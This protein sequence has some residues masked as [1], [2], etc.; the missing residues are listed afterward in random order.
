[1]IL[2]SNVLRAQHYHAVGQ[3]LQ[4]SNRRNLELKYDPT[5][6]TLERQDS[7]KAIIYSIGKSKVL[8]RVELSLNSNAAGWELSCKVPDSTVVVSV[9]FESPDGQKDNNK[10]KGYLL[11]LYRKSKPL[12]FAY[13]QMSNMVSGIPYG[14]ERIKKDQALALT[15]MK[16][17]LQY[18]P[19]HESQ[20]R[21]NY[22]NML[23]NSPSKE[24]KVLLV[25]KLSQMR[26]D[27]EEDLMMAQLYLSYFGSKQQADS[28][29][30]LLKARFPNGQYVQYLKQKESPAPHDPKP[31]TA[32]N[33]AP[34]RVLT[35][36]EVNDMLIDETVSALT[37][38]DI[39]GNSVEIGAG[40]LKGK[41]IVLDFWATWCGPCVASFPGMQT[42]MK[43]YEGRNDIVFL[44]IAT[45]EKGDAYQNVRNFLS[46]HKYPFIM[47]MDE[48]TGEMNM[49]KAYSHY[50]LEG[51][52]PYKIIIDKKGHIRFRKNGFDGNSAEM[53]SEL[54]A[55]I[56]SIDK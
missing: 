12:P 25:Q 31:L 41:I 51:G 54:S 11:P 14:D 30:Q 5:G 27:K 21:N 10:G 28:L 13:A 23:A 2:I 17:E 3:N 20:L 48:P 56:D 6:T 46:K 50:K 49:Y 8:Q 15:Y 39:N 45:M 16:Q 9:S 34:V 22:F 47:L 19:D 18:Y 36:S 24:D 53:V 44:Y 35:A 38:K 52:I 55:I 32:G 40:D 1:M 26:S 7:I 42:V 33:N 37:L 4:Y 29:D 43:K